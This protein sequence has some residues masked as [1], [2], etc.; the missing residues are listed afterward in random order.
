MKLIER[1][2][3]EWEEL[4]NVIDFTGHS[5]GELEII[6]GAIQEHYDIDCRKVVNEELG[7]KRRELEYAIGVLT[8]SI[9]NREN[10]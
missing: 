4:D 1:L 6:Y 9:K 7:A 8:E 3:T 2:K 10:E 5:K